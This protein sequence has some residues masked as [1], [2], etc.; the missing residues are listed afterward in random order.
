MASLFFYMKE[1]L[2]YGQSTQA[3][4]TPI[5][6]NIM[7]ICK[8]RFELANHPI[9]GINCIIKLIT[10]KINPTISSNPLRWAK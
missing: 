2:G 6:A 4:N 9:P 10:T 3:N 5:I 8:K 1:I 7:P